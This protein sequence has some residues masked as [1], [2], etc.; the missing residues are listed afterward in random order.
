MKSFQDKVALITG[1]SSGIGRATAIAFAREGAKV[2]VTSRRENEGKET[3]R[4]IKEVGSEGLF[5]RTDVSKEVDVKAMVEETVKAYGHLDYA[6]N[7]A[8]IEGNIAPLAEQTV[9]DYESVLGIN[10]RG[11]F[12]SMKYEIPQMLKNGGGAIVNMSS[13]LGLIG[14]P[15][16]AL[17]VASKHAVLG[18]TK[19]AAL[20]YAKSGIRINA[21]SPGAIETDMVD[22]FVGKVGVGKEGELRQQVAAMH[23][24]GRMGKPEEIAS[25]VLY[26]CSDGASFVTGQTLALDGGFTAQ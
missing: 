18:L 24:I 2:V 8:G 9:D 16:T 1:G 25:A 7:N 6:F 23:P 19:S 17:Y 11:V 3:V 14:F 5:I 12:L 20:E 10:V 21:V 4:L 26:L 15:G 13:V 22:R